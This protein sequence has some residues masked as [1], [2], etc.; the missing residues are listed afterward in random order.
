MKLK[1][2]IN[3]KI[4]IFIALLIIIL[5]GFS[6]RLKTGIEQNFWL[7]EVR[8]FQTSQLPLKKLIFMNHWDQAHPQLFYIF[9][10]FWSKI[11]TTVTFLRIPSIISFFPAIILI[12]LI[13]KTLKNHISGL[14]SAFIFSIHPFFVNLG[15]QQKMYGFEIALM[16]ASLY[17]NIQIIKTKKT[18]WIILSI[19]SNILAFFTDYSF[20]W[21][22]IALIV[23]IVLLSAFTKNAKKRLFPIL[24]ATIITIAVIS[25][26]I[27]IF[28]NGLSQALYLE[29]YLG[30][31]HLFR[32]QLA[33]NNFSGL[34]TL[35]IKNNTKY[36]LL[37]LC[38]ILLI[39]TILNSKFLYKKVL[40]LII[41]NSFLLSL[42]LSFLI[43][44]FA[45][46]FVPRNM[47]CAAFIFIFGIPLLIQVTKNKIFS[48]VIFLMLSIIYFQTLISSSLQKMHFRGQTPWKTITAFIN[49]YQNNKTIIFIGQPSY[50]IAP[51]LE[52]Y[53]PGYNNNESINDYNYFY[54]KNLETAISRKYEKINNEIFIIYNYF[55]EE[56]ISN[57]SSL[58]KKRLNC[59]SNN[60]HYIQISL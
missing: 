53:F 43:S 24:K 38:A 18:K 2:L 14:T 36:F 46:I 6:L 20:I 25:I 12:F 42:S 57:N 41:I 59:Y 29:K 4:F 23:S 54:N 21:Y 9:I 22:F 27:P 10:H 8:I 39:K 5:I 56:K 17:S 44:Q 28:L 31:I 11:N 3:K 1:L 58:L 33:V 52:Y 51:L 45:P 49:Q 35:S 16:L 37:I 34:Y 47:F 32:L 30:K 50:K 40:S 48:S 19:I 13:G 7:D 55:L 26:Q 15:F 60:C